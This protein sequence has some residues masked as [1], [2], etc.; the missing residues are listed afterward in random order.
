MSSFIRKIVKPA[1]FLKDSMAP[2]ET[3]GAAPETDF[4]EKTVADWSKHL[5]S[6]T[7]GSKA[8]VSIQRFFSVGCT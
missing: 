5:E 7:F 6:P 3:Y 2:L 4:F 1:D 8:P